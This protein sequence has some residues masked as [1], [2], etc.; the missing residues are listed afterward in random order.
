MSEIIPQRL[1]LRRQ[2]IEKFLY[3]SR[4]WRLLSR[5]SLELM[6]DVGIYRGLLSGKDELE[7]GQTLPFFPRAGLVEAS[8]QSF[9][10]RSG[11]LY[12]DKRPVEIPGEEEEDPSTFWLPPRFLRE[13]SS[14]DNSVIS[15]G[16]ESALASQN[17]TLFLAFK[18][19]DQAP[20]LEVEAQDTGKILNFRDDEDGELYIELSKTEGG[21]QLSFTFIDF[22]D[23][24]QIGSIPVT[25]D[26]KDAYIFARRSGNRFYVEINGQVSQNA[27]DDD[28]KTFLADEECRLRIADWNIGHD[29]EL[30]MLYLYSE[31][32]DDNM[33]QRLINRAR[34][35]IPSAAFEGSMMI[36]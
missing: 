33:K 11:A 21:P 26:S 4:L 27:T 2:K 6:F 14:L 17:W 3:R 25:I 7:E 19:L 9:E 31:A 18:D 22:D 30:A 23:D 24:Y 12:V 20:S 16:I 28:V 36:F 5:Q 34:A 29:Y 1:V 8:D 32:L 10:I 15:E 35:I 13:R